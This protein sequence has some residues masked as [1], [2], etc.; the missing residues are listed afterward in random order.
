MLL[1]LKVHLEAEREVLQLQGGYAAMANFPIYEKITYRNGNKMICCLDG[2]R[3][4]IQ[5]EISLT[6]EP[7]ELFYCVIESRPFLEKMVVREHI[8]PHFLPIHEA[9]NDY[10]TSN[11]TKFIDHV[12]DLLQAYVD[13]REQVRIIEVLYRN[14]I[15]ELRSSNS[16]DMIELVFAGFDC[17]VVASLRYADLVSTLPSE[18][19]VLAWPMQPSTKSRNRRKALGHRHKPARLSLAEYVLQ[20]VSLPEG[21]VGDANIGTMFPGYRNSVLDSDENHSRIEE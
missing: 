20:S 12:G 15:G 6:G 17:K 5:Y 1:V 19:V 14:R 16:F 8:I 21:Y 11:A 10:L 7:C 18:V 2:A 3:I 4:G 9:E 13:R